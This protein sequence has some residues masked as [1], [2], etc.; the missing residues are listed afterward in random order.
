M[1]KYILKNYWTLV[2]FSLF[3]RHYA[4]IDTADYL[5]DGLFIKHKVP[6]KFLQ[7]LQSPDSPYC[8]ILCKVRKRDEGL[9][10]VALAELPNK[11]LL[12]GYADYAD[13]C[14][15]IMRETGA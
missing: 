15:K 1:Q 10:L 7:A 9:F 4:Y 13:F 8:V 6:V 11:M 3:H 5:A 2:K 14:G 12:L